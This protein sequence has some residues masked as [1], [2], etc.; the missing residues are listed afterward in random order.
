MS[1]IRLFVRHGKN[2]PK[3][4]LFSKFG[5]FSSTGAGTTSGV[6]SD[7]LGWYRANR[8]NWRA[9]QRAKRHERWR[10]IEEIAK[11]WGCDDET[12]EA[13]WHEEQLSD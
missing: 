9:E 4:F 7:V 11:E 8:N 2:G 5:T 3:A 6:V 1:E 13:I 10:R 12:A